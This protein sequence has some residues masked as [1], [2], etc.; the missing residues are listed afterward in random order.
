MRIQFLKFLCHVGFVKKY[1]CSGNIYIDILK[2]AY[3]LKYQKFSTRYF[4]ILG[5]N[6]I[7]TYT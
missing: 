3:D 5:T 1:A 2:Q 4:D 6:T 7:H